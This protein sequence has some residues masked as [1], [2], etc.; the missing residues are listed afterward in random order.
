ML[1]LSIY[2]IIVVILLSISLN[3]NIA[4][5]VEIY[6]EGFLNSQLPDNLPFSTDTNRYSDGFSSSSAYEST[7][8]HFP[9]YIGATANVSDR[10]IND[11]KYKASARE[12]GVGIRGDADPIKENA[13]YLIVSKPGYENLP[14]PSTTFN[15]YAAIKWNPSFF[16]IQEGETYNI[17]V[18]G[19]QSGYSNQF[20][21]DGGIRVNAEGYESSF[22][23]ISNCYI[24]LGRC[25]SHLKQKR[26]LLTAPWMSLAC[27][28]GSFVRPLGEIKPGEESKASY[29]P[30]D[31]AVLQETIFYVGKSIEFKSKYDGQLM[32]FANDGQNLYWNNKGFLQVTVTRASW[33]PT[34]DLYYSPLYLPSCDS[35]FVVYQNKGNNDPATAKV[36]C[37]PTGGG[38]GWTLSAITNTV[39]QYGSDIPENILNKDPFR[40]LKT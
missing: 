6:Q 15:V 23:P 28:V 36:K 19:S 35:A 26:R 8:P 9:T 25:R 5:A 38:A 31:E 24:A 29:L 11:K 27:A 13:K 14:A 32:C 12:Q 17:T 18:F 10:W 40:K 7:A 4:N 37:N 39:T 30:M 33:P 3:D 34:P 21:Q 20:W 22:D 1:I 16:A 2:L